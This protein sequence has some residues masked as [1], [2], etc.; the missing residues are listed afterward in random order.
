MRRDRTLRPRLRRRFLSL[1]LWRSRIL[2]RCRGV[3]LQLRRSGPLRLCGRRRCRCG[4]SRLRWRCRL[5]TL[6]RLLLLLLARWLLRLRRWLPLVLLRRLRLRRRRGTLCGPRW[7]RAELA[8]FPLRQ[9]LR[10]RHGGSRLDR[11]GG[12]LDRDRGNIAGGGTASAALTAVTASRSQLVR[13]NADGAGHTLRACDDP[14]GHLEGLQR[15]PARPRDKSRRHASVDGGAAAPVTKR[16]VDDDSL[17]ENH[18]T[19]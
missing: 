17:P 6:L 7:V 8:A 5:W 15:R 19:A 11:D 2:L 14:R 16:A 4:W 3:L 13:G 12:W 10:R 18:R 9:W 1:R